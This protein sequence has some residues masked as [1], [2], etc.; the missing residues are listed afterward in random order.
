VRYPIW[1]MLVCG[2]LLACV[3]GLRVAHADS[4]PSKHPELVLPSVESA[5]SAL[6]SKKRIAG[7]VVLVSHKGRVIHFT[8]HGHRDLE[9]RLPMGKDSLFRIYSMTKPITSVVAMM[10]VEEGA[11]GLDVPIERYL[12]EL[13]GLKRYTE[14]G[15]VPVRS[16]PTVRQLLNHTA[17]FTYGYF[18]DSA[19]DKM[20]KKT[21]PLGAVSNK[22]MVE[23]LAKLPLLHEPGTVWHYSVAS[24]ILGHLLE[25]VEGQSLGTLLQAR[26]FRPLGMSDTYFVV[27]ATESF[28]LTS[29]YTRGL[30]RTE[31]AKGSPFLKKGRIESGGG[32]LVSTAEDYLRFCRFLLQEGRVGSRK[33]LKPE[34]VRQMVGNQ[35]PSGE[36]AYGFFGF[37]FGFM[38]QLLDW[39]DKGPV[40]EYGWSGAASTHFWI[41]PRDDIVAIALSQRMPFTTELKK[42]LKPVIYRSVRRLKK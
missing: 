13:K 16:P 39:A 36:K 9:R 28:R 14:D 42:R 30:K 4:E 5:I 40:G 1:L 10:L 26:L 38:V 2:L 15:L 37:G 34:T 18:S 20:Y 35:L 6:V 22:A 33:L 32:G 7:A 8:A 27:P 23:Q 17:G 21:H 41:S 31:G 3:P 24:D 12:P 29:V 11:L 19:V 25:R